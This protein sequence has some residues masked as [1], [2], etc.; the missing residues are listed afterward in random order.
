[1]LVSSPGFVSYA[2]M[3]TDKKYLFKAKKI[4]DKAPG[5]KKADQPMVSQSTTQAETAMTYKK[6]RHYLASGGPFEPQAPEEVSVPSPTS[7]IPIPV[8]DLDKDVE[9]SSPASTVGTPTVVTQVATPPTTLLLRL[10]SWPLS[11]R[12]KSSLPNLSL[13]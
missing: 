6:R 10:P 11:S 8:V 3:K 13:P 4:K 9:G 1:M 2:T 7:S 12:P 5:A